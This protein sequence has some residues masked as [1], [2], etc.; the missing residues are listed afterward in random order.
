M[1]KETWYS[2]LREDNAKQR[3]RNKKNL[4]GADWDLRGASQNKFGGHKTKA[5]K[6]LK[7]STFGAANGGKSLSPEEISKA[8]A[9]LKVRGLI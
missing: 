9:D 3:Q 6:G 8:I 2:F 1:V 4:N 7:G 5:L